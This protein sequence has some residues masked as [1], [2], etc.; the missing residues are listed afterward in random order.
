MAASSLCVVLA[1]ERGR[2]L[3]AVSMSAAVIA[4]CHWVSGFWLLAGRDRACCAA[5]FRRRGFALPKQRTSESTPRLSFVI[6]HLLRLKNSES[7]PDL[8]LAFWV[9]QIV[10]LAF[11]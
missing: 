3:R 7:L 9:S 6:P 5:L 10:E 11:K 1:V 4:V 8:P 2:S